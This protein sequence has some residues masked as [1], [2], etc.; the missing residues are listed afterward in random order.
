MTFKPLIFFFFLGPEVVGSS[1]YKKNNGIYKTIMFRDLGELPG[2]ISTKI[3][4]IHPTTFKDAGYP[5]STIFLLNKL[6]QNHFRYI[7]I[8]VAK[9]NITFFKPINSSS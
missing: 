4:S 7:D 5:N 1:L 6:H 9:S 2:E 8:N 3:K